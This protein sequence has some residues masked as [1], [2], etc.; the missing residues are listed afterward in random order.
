MAILSKFSLFF[1]HKC[2][3]GLASIVYLEKNWEVKERMNTRMKVAVVLAAISGVLLTAAGSVAY[4]QSTTQQSGQASCGSMMNRNAGMGM[5][6]G[7]S[8]YG[9]M[10]QSQCNSH[11]GQQGMGQCQDLMASR[12]PTQPPH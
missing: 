3:P 12:Y 4:A 11:M 6:G 7:M 5:M 8:H 10:T 2:K 1:S 9:S